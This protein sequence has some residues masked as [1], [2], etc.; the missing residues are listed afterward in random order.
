MAIR[1][2]CLVTTENPLITRIR[3]TPRNEEAT[4]ISEMDDAKESNGLILWKGMVY[5]PKI[6]RKEVLAESHNRE[7]AGHFGNDKTIE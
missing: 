1:A 6:L 4:R 2:T 3:R 5:V 7:T